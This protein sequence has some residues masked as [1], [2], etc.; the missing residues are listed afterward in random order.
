[1]GTT[2]YL[3]GERQKNVKKTVLCTFLGSVTALYFFRDLCAG[4]GEICLFA[5]FYDR[6]SVCPFVGKSTQILLLGIS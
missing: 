1:M 6:F 3:V 2:S 4:A 5:K